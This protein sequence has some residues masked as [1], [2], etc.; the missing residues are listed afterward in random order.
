MKVALDSKIHIILTHT[1]LVSVDRTRGLTDP[2]GGYLT[3]QCLTVSIILKWQAETDRTIRWVRNSS[4]SKCRGLNSTILPQRFLS[5][6]P[7]A[8]DEL[9]IR[10]WDHSKILEYGTDF[11]RQ[12]NE[13]SWY[14]KKTTVRAIDDLTY[15]VASTPAKH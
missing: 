14:G 15:F 3:I 8:G 10:P 6:R 9:L 13:L 11:Q 5:T 1:G 2:M 12:T 7:L 4:E